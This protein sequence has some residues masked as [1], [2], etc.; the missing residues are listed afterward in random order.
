MVRNRSPTI[1]H[2]R[3]SRAAI[4][5]LHA[6]R[7]RQATNKQPCTTGLSN[8][9]ADAPGPTRRLKKQSKSNIHADC[10]PE[11]EWCSLTSLGRIKDPRKQPR[12]E[13]SSCSPAT[14]ATS[15][16][17]TGSSKNTNEES[18]T[19]GCRPS[20]AKSKGQPSKGVKTSD[21]RTVSISKL[22]T[23]TARPIP[24]TH[25]PSRS[26]FRVYFIPQA[27]SQAAKRSACRH[28]LEN[29]RANTKPY[30]IVVTKGLTRSG[31]CLLERLEQGITSSICAVHGR[32]LACTRRRC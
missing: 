19:A 8:S 7:T 21:A 5:S 14:K 22:V 29:E 31:A 2:T 30:E 9:N 25:D 18:R 26:R 4:H 24:V 15:G 20:K 1:R 28:F 10:S 17:S 27:K 32:G 6:N 11:L 16:K 13:K 23:F 3:H 12:A